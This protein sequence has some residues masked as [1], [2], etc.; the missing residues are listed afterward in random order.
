[1]SLSD[2]EV[3]IEVL[4]WMEEPRRF[5]DCDCGIP[6]FLRVPALIADSRD[7][8]TICQLLTGRG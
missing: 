8:F 7:S 4:E 6:F 2:V 1:V 5:W 3:G